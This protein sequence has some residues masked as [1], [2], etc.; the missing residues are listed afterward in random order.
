MLDSPERGEHMDNS[1]LLVVGRGG[2][3]MTLCLSLQEHLLELK[4]SKRQVV[5]PKES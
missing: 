5:T 3:N 1:G 4:P 2:V